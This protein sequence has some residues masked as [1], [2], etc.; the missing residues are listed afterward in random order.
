MSLQGNSPGLIPQLYSANNCHFQPAVAEKAIG[1]LLG[2]ALG[3]MRRSKPNAFQVLIICSWNATADSVHKEVHATAEICQAQ[4]LAELGSVAPEKLGL[5]AFLEPR[6]VDRQVPKTAFQTYTHD[7]NPGSRE[8]C[9]KFL[10]DCQSSSAPSAAT[11][12][13]L[14][15]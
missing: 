3:S 14:P 6:A 12:P 7:D 1:L 5:A 8:I 13:F 2:R 15:P 9:E 10:P 11:R 4:T